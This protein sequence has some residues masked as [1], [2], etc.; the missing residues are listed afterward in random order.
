[1]CCVLSNLLLCGTVGG[2]LRPIKKPARIT[3]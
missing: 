3:K 1:M 2:N